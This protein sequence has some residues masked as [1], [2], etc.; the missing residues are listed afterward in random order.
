[1]KHSKLG[2][3]KSL[4]ILTKLGAKFVLRMYQLGYQFSHA[5][6]TKDKERLPKDT[7]ISFL[8]VLNLHQVLR[9]Y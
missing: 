1:M 3:K 2:W 5:R 8:N 7:P 6:A 9:S 4:L